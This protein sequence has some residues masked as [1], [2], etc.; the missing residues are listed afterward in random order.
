MFSEADFVP[1]IYCAPLDINDGS[2]PQP[3]PL[4]M[5]HSVHMEHFKA[6]HVKTYDTLKSI[7]T[8]TSEFKNTELIL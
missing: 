1:S 4:S 5:P 8:N 3:T 7:K 6:D 2:F